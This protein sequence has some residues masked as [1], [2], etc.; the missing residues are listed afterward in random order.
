LFAGLFD[1]LTAAVNEKLKPKG[2]AHNLFIG[3]LDMFGFENFAKNGYEQLCINYANE[4]L[5]HQFFNHYFTAEQ[6]DYVENGL[7]WNRIEAPTQANQGTSATGNC[8][9][10]FSYALFAFYCVL[11]FVSLIVFLFSYISVSFFSSSSNRGS[12]FSRASMHH[13]DGA[14]VPI[15]G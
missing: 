9:L 2:D 1:W 13:S 10:V 5:Q 7:P 15:N 3:I 12:L 8:L 6:N 11:K 4:K 14:T